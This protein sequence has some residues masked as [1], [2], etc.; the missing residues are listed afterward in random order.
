MR[1][2]QSRMNLADP[3]TLASLTLSKA[4]LCFCFLVLPRFLAKGP[5]LVSVFERLVCPRM[6]CAVSGNWWLQ[7]WSF[8]TET[9][10]WTKG[11]AASVR[12][13]RWDSRQSPGV[14]RHSALCFSSTHLITAIFSLSGE[15]FNEIFFSINPWVFS[16]RTQAD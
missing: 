16:T 11:A 12:T 3:G 10:K 15:L 14:F 7:K 6:S 5:C 13:L 8:L 2:R 4:G 9:V 1:W